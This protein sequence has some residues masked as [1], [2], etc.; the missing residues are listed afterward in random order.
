MN[1]LQL[2][3]FLDSQNFYLHRIPRGPYLQYKLSEKDNNGNYKRREN[4][5]NFISSSTLIENGEKFYH[6]SIDLLGNGTTTILPRAKILNTS[7]S[8]TSGV[9]YN[10][11]T[12]TIGRF[13]PPKLATITSTI[14]D[15]KQNPKSTKIIPVVPAK[16]QM[17]Y[18]TLPSTRRECQSIKRNFNTTALP[19]YITLENALSYE[20]FH[21]LSPA[22]GWALL[23]QSIQALQDLFLSGESNFLFFLS[24]VCFKPSEKSFN[25][26]KK[27]FLIYFRNLKLSKK[28]SCRIFILYSFS[29]G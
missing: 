28:V 11:R 26:T 16:Q 7:L 18:N 6:S 4:K 17:G 29:Q 27:L 8:D 24:F 25:L 5:P 10:L 12:Q 20:F 23:C 14:S 13:N 21:F 1:K 9:D 3:I 15:Y 22:Q 19:S 2:I